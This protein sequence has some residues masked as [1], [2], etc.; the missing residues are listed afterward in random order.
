MSPEHIGTMLFKLYLN[1]R[2]RPWTVPKRIQANI[3][4]GFSTFLKPFVGS[5]KYRPE[6]Y[7]HMICTTCDKI[8]VASGG[9]RQL[10]RW[11][12]IGCA[13]EGSLKGSY[14]NENGQQCETLITDD[15]CSQFDT[16]YTNP[17]HTSLNNVDTVS[18]EIFY[19]KVVKYFEEKS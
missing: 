5:G 4:P 10:F 15:N 12:C 2:K 16:Y 11:Y 18:R 19:R 13:T 17:L 9:S 14:N 7:G 3:H 8:Y 1:Y 6:L